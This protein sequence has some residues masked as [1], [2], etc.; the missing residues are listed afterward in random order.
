MLLLAGDLSVL[1]GYLRLVFAV[2]GVVPVIKFS[3]P[4]EV[5][6][7]QGFSGGVPEW[8]KGTGCKPVGSGLHRF[9]SYPLHFSF[10]FFSFSFAG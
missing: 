8:L 1:K 4:F 3:R 7:K 5:V 2:I 6:R 9:E 10:F